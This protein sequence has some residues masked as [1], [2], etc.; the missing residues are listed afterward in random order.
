M[1]NTA[2]RR[3]LSAFGAFL[4]L[5]AGCSRTPRPPAPATAQTV[6][7]VRAT[8]ATVPSPPSTGDNTLI[9]T[10]TDPATGAPIGDANLTVKT[11]S[12][13]PRLP[14]AVT[15]GRAQG[16]GVY[17]IPVRLAIASSYQIELQVQRIGR[18]PV[19]FTF[20]LSATQ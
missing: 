10:L 16:N 14:G 4:A 9:V 15:T 11:V 12:L 6:G 17:N 18:P 2:A 20:P 19:T 3:T 1:R 7:D 8:L 13:A 5:S